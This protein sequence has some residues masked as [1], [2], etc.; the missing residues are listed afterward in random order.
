MRAL[1]KTMNIEYKGKEYEMKIL[2]E[3]RYGKEG[4]ITL[5]YIDLEDGT[6]L[7]GVAERS[8]RDTYDKEQGKV[9]AIGRL[10]KKVKKRTQAI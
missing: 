2:Q 4:E 9:V 7:I 3:A 1:V 6:Q 10:R 8:K 5:A